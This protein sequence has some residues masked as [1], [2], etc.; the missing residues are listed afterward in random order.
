MFHQTDVFSYDISAVAIVLWG[1]VWMKMVNASFHVK[2]QLAPIYGL[3][4]HLA[5]TVHGLLIK[6]KAFLSN[7]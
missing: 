3:A 6:G 5:G 2:I 4:A 1:F 7:M